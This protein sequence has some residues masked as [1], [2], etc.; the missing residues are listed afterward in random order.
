MRST[1]TVVFVTGIL[2]FF[3]ISLSFVPGAAAKKPKVIKLNL[4]HVFPATHTL[5]K[6]FQYFADQMYERSNGRVQITVYPVG[7]LISPAKLYEGTVTGIVDIGSPAVAYT[8]GRLPAN[9]A[10]HVPL[11]SKTGWVTTHVAY[12]FQREFN[13]KETHQVHVLFGHACGTYTIATRNRPVRKLED[14]AGLKIRASGAA[15]VAFVEAL[16]ASPEAMPMS[17][18]YEA[19]AKGVIDSLFVPFE[20]MKGYKHAEVTKYVTIPPITCSNNQ[21]T[22]MNLKKWNSLPEDIQRVFTEVSSEMAEKFARSWWYI[23][24]K[25]KEYFLNQDEGR[26]VI[27]IPPE[28]EPAWE[29]TIQPL[30]DKYIED[31]TAMG[32]PA[33]KYEEYCQERAK[34]WNARHLDEKTC[35]EWVEKNV[36]K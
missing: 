7:T 36:L 29:K 32:L 15:T 23:D 35:V 9:E 33:A 22:I 18:A 11:P 5:A 25:G 3:L 31:K 2:V 30:V 27:E 4:T 1:R 21:L 13:P 16:G 20:T 10:T 28:Q 8:P 17:E 26:E 34:Y 14:A 12:D 19:A 24:I 6:T